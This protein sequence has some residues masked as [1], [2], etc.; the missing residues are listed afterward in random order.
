[1]ISSDEMDTS[2]IL[3]KGKT[4]AEERNIKDIVV[5]STSGTTGLKAA[6]LFEGSNVNLVVVAHSTGFRAPNEQEFSEENLQHI[7]ELGG[8]VF[9]GPMIFHNINSAIGEQTGFSAL[10]LVADVLRLFGQ[11]TKVALECVL[12]ACDAGLIDAGKEVISVAGTG[13]GADTALLIRSS[14]SKDLFNARIRE[15]LLKPSKPENLPL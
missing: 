13:R 3:T 14:N 10:N 9:V 4:F 11:G 12:M 5:A 6:K 7:K 15:V 2:E 1:M 8:R